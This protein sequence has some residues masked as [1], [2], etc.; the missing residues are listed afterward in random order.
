MSKGFLGVL[1]AIILIFAGVVAFSGKSES[2]GGSSGKDKASGPTNH[3]R[4]QGTAGVKLVEYGDFQCPACLSYEPT[5][6]Q[7]RTKYDEQITFQFRHFPI[8]SSHPN[9]FAA[10]RAAEAAGL[11]GKFWEMHDALY[12]QQNWQVW[13]RSNGPTAEFNRYAQQIGLNV[14][15]FKKDFAS[16]RVNDAVNADMAEGNRLKVDST[17]T[18][19]IDGKKTVIN[20]SLADFDKAIQ[21]AIA[22][23]SR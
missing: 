12:D 20:N 9:A 8:I 15:Q 19:F 5:V 21:A 3:V 23:K 4:G 2:P 14:V 11:Q 17:P 6:Q 10:A 18:F 22:K 7:V 1:A 16:S 13:T